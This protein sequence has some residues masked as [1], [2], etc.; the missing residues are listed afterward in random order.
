[1]LKNLILAMTVL[2]L[3]ACAFDQDKNA[4]KQRENE[5]NQA[6]QKSYKP[7]IGTYK[8][9]LTTADGAQEVDLVF[10]DLKVANGKNSDGSTR[11]VSQLHA[12][13][14][15]AG[16]NFDFIVALTE[17]TCAISMVNLKD[18]SGLGR[19]DIQTIDA[20]V[21]GEKIVGEAKGIAGSIGILDVV[22]KT[23]ENSGGNSGREEVAYYERIRAK[24]NTIV[25][26][27]TGSLKQVGGTFDG[28]SVG[29]T[30]KLYIQEVPNGAI[31]I[32]TLIGDFSRA[33]D[34]SGTVALN[35]KGEFDFESNP[36]R[37]TLEGTPRFNPGSNYKAT[38]YGTVVNGAFAGDM[39][40]SVGF[41]GGK[42][43]L[44]KQP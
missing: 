41:G 44:E 38:I 12:T 7:V 29:I 22:L 30:V 35:L 14:K 37:L 26:T 25:G 15:K 36:A 27:Y 33:D 5:R 31:T 1:M 23:R 13:L 16:G 4:D 18:L 39:T 19:D 20:R 17:E 28:K 40:T 8:G 43:T 10:F 32:P 34:A 24:L 2:S 21:N 3:S 42:F 6:L 11:L 9:T